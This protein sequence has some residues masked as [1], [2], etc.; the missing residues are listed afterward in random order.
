[1]S[2]MSA[3]NRYQKY[4]SKKEDEA[5]VPEG[6][7]SLLPMRGKP[8][9]SASAQEIG[10]ET[11]EDSEAAVGGTSE[12][13]DA[14]AALLHI[15][16]SSAIA[17]S[18]GSVVPDDGQAD[19]PAFSERTKRVGATSAFE[20][21]VAGPPPKES[22]QPESSLAASPRQPLPDETL[23]SDE[24]IVTLLRAIENTE[25]ARSLGV[26]A[27]RGDGTPRAP[28]EAEPKETAADARAFEPGVSVSL[29]K[30]PA[31]P[32]AEPTGAS[33]A[34]TVVES[35][36]ASPPP[37]EFTQQDPTALTPP[38]PAM[39]AARTANDNS[40]STSLPAAGQAPAE[41]P[42]QRSIPANDAAPRIPSFTLLGAEKGRLAATCDRIVD[43]L[44]YAEMK[45]ESWFLKWFAPPDPRRS[46]RVIDPL[47]VAYHWLMDVPQGLRVAN[48]SAG[49]L[50][51]ITEERW[52]SGNIISMTLQRTD[53]EK[54]SPDSWIAVDF[55]VVRW[56]KDGIVGEFLPSW[57]DKY[58]TVAG[59]AGNSAD[60]RT[61]EKFVQQLVP[62]TE[63]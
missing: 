52:P 47:L 56:C 8:Q 54:G 53:R 26:V 62:G 58:F 14:T 61:L 27:H 12:S 10:S 39:A 33:E 30:E 29:A 15:I 48:I 4:G 51:L 37:S 23:E 25:T 60:K 59:R 43:G 13:D 19:E 17:K 6:G 46:V 38:L 16:E 2:L 9:H 20:P 55:V 1:M 42:T 40:H 31:R 49:G 22:V 35:P 44:D 50:Y 32:E 11:T 34:I 57:P 5:L 18:L 41:T 3:A 24:S 7:L 21:S 28:V 63:Q 36:E 45:L